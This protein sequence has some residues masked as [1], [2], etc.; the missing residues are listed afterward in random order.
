MTVG[1]LIK[2]KDYDYI[3]YRTILPSHC[4]VG[5]IFTGVAKS[6]NGKLISLDGDSHSENEEIFLYNE[7]SKPSIGIE[8]GLTV[9][10]E[11][12]WNL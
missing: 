6:K 12:E 8:N 1:D 3:S 5:D 9:F 4:G 11:C 10:Y 7:W 2:N